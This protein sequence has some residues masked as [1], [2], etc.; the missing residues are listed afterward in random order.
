MTLWGKQWLLGKSTL[1]FLG[2]CSRKGLLH[3]V[4][5]PLS[6][7]G[8][9]WN[10]NQIFKKRELIGPQLLEGGG[11]IFS[12]EVAIFTEK[13]NENMKYLMIKKVKSKNIFIC[14]S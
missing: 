13:I 4:H 8:E 6:G 11:W 2:N 3:S 10:S 7:G 14:H 1:Y 12:G 5:P 9:G